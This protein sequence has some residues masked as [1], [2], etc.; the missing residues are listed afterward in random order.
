MPFISQFCGL[1]LGA[2]LAFTQERERRRTS[3]RVKGKRKKGDFLVL[4]AVFSMGD[5]ARKRGRRRSWYNI[6]SL[7]ELSF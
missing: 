4:R 1:G 7:N 2:S 6:K 5:T 3:T